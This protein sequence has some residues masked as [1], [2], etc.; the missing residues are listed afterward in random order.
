MLDWKKVL[1][2]SVLSSSIIFSSF[3]PLIGNVSTAK[4]ESHD[5]THSSEE[6]LPFLSQHVSGPFDL[7]LVNE[8]KLLPSLI[9]Q[10]IVDEDASPEE[11][12][13]QMQTYLKKRSAKAEKLAA[14][15]EDQ[16]KV[17]T[18]LQRKANLKKTAPVSPKAGEENKVKAQ[19][20]K[21]SGIEEEDWD[22]DVQTDQVL[23]LLID[24]PDYSNSSI[25][26]ADNPVLLYDNYTKEHYENMV[27]GDETYKGG[28][29]EDFISM[30]EFYEQQS[31]GSYTIDGAVSEW[32]TAE[33]PAAYYG[34]NY[35]TAEDSDIRP[36]ELIK[37]ALAHAA[38]D[39]NIDLAQFDQED[40]YDLDGDGNYREPDGIIDHLMIVHAGT[41]E[42]AGG[43]AL[44]AD[45]IWSHSWNLEDVSVIPETDGQAEVDYWGGGLAALDYT[46]QPE[47]GA[48]GV[49]AHEFGHDLGLP[50]HYDTNYT[51]G[52]VGAPT[53]YWTIMASGSW[54]GLIGGTEPTGFSPY[55]KEYLQN[56]M[57]ES[58]WFKDVEYSLE[59]IQSGKK[60]LDLDQASVKGTN[61]DSVK[62]TLPDK[63]T[64]INTPT[65]GEF[66]YHSG[67]GNDLDNN[68]ST[69]V[70]LTDVSNAE[71]TFNAFYDIEEH[72]DYAS[73]Q[74]KDGS[75]QWATV[76][77][78]I[79]T[80][81][82]PYDQSPGHGITGTSN[83]WKEASFDLS[84]FAGQ[85][86]EL[87]INYWTDGYVAMPGL[88]VDDIKVIADGADLVTDDAESETSAF[89][90]KGFTKTDGIKT[91][92]HYYL[93][94]WRNYAAAD[95]ALAHIPRGNSIMTLDP[96]MVV[97]YVDNKYDNNW[98][99]DHPG[100]GFNGV[101]DAH[102]ATAA[103]S[104]GVVGA[105][106]YQ[107][108]DAAFSLNATDKMYLD[109]KDING[110]FMELASQ[111]AKPVF[112][113]DEDYSNPGQI[114]SGRNVPGY[115]LDI[116][117]LEQ[118]AD[119]TT[120][121]VQIEFD[122]R[123]P[124]GTLTGLEEVYSSNEGHNKINVTVTANDGNLDQ[125]VTISSKVLNS[126]E[127]VVASVEDAFVSTRE[128]QDIPVEVTL[129]E[130]LESGSYTL[131][132][133]V[134][135]GTL[136]SSITETFTVD[137]EAPTPEL[138]NNGSTEVTA[139]PSVTVNV[140]DAAE[141]TLEYKWS[142]SEDAASDSSKLEGLQRSASETEKWLPFTNGDALTLSGVE[143]K[144][145]LHV[146]G[147]DI[148]G[149]NIK[150]TSNP[151]TVDGVGPAITL[152]GENPFVMDVDTEF[153]DP[154]Y[155]AEDFTDGDVTNK[156]DVSGEV[157]T[158][159]PGEYILTY[160][161]TD[162]LGNESSVQRR[163]HVVDQVNP[164]IEL[165]GESTIELE[166]GS[167]YKEPGFT[168]TDNVDGDLTDK[169]VVTGTVNTAVPGEYTLTYTVAD[170]SDNEYSVTRTVTVV[171][172]TAPA[173]ELTDGAELVVEGATTFT[174]PGFTAT[175]AVDGDLTDEVTVSG[176]VDVNTA[177][178]YILTYTVT[179]AA[180]NTAAVKRTVTVVDTTAPVI[181]LSG[182]NPVELDFGQY[183]VEP[184]F[185]AED[186]MDGNLTDHVTV[187]ST[188]RLKSGT[189]H[190]TYSVS[191]KAGNKTSVTRTVNVKQASEATLDV[192][193]GTDRVG[194]AIEVSKEMYP[195]GGAETVLITT[196]YNFP[197]ALSAG[198][199]ASALDAPIIPVTADGEL[200]SAALAEL[201]RLGAENVYLVGGKAAV[202]EGVYTQLSGIG[203]DKDNIDRLSGKDR[204]ETNLAIVTELK[205]LGFEGNGVFLATGANYAD[206][207][208]A[209]S[210][211]GA[212]GMPIV[213]TN[214]T[215]L[216]KEAEAILKGEDVYA[217]GGTAA[218]TDSVIKEAKA[219]SKSVKRLSGSDRYAT[220]VE[221]LKE[222][223]VT[224]DKIFVA[225]GKNYPDALSATPFVNQN[226]GLLLLVNPDSLPEEVKNFLTK[227]ANTTYVSAVTVLGGNSAVGTDVKEEL[228]KAVR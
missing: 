44:G 118:A 142:N 180:E 210:I 176:K 107:I 133:D 165:T 35:P 185:A 168:A 126:D 152:K 103:W 138:D 130:G 158:E 14:D 219:V 154:G 146:R 170:S 191:D 117:V 84:E 172:T 208:S 76:A 25:T 148:V 111:P 37:E 74:V 151:F 6:N 171:D 27:F 137:N 73:V 222:F 71:L 106:R 81:A 220:L 120:A 182:N 186:T 187:T 226:D 163:V 42:E 227:Y 128:S 11:Q 167:E 207:L 156:V 119:M 211:A 98:V 48:A 136:D 77:G 59:D 181:T 225:S 85:E 67:S 88:Y 68:L 56:R 30:K 80:D 21:V 72:W 92:E 115:G 203:I 129:P 33:H 228:L 60:V 89:T 55:D 63:K 113:D 139:Q 201:K 7:G 179:D 149:N 174:D 105:T 143:G 124:T 112:N 87:K 51:A 141:G 46:V 5:H 209:G 197:D 224:T 223:N 45:A 38:K 95:T 122:D 79:T 195:E 22:G 100:D 65:S 91:S 31:G 54:A 109:Y 155:T 215:D 40:L 221:L 140:K 153:V 94:E 26:E 169:V 175:D 13:K 177:G 75:G 184:G 23:V 64:V 57:P 162:S 108:Q 61:A 1:G 62:I 135:D 199:L 102:Q 189:Y 178:E 3:A 93:V 16:K 34:G 32:Y 17:R 213:L 101:V 188:L 9:K 192:V 205:E 150:F 131:L 70:D 39:P 8:E 161:A 52:G 125:E 147:K 121:K 53:D 196:G 206:A 86:I 28:N 193:S 190:V 134:S 159:V 99:G 96:G 217:A 20:N 43:G 58:N 127:E 160:S 132:V 157:N 29:G 104:D 2:T 216:S 173:I 144:W 82:N 202:N 218:I 183:F 78:N 47:D 194:T 41:G 116:S 12:R 123:T 18:E 214:G 69:K 49:F 83:G 145:Y 4:A 200:S 66:E 24:F 114:Y 166:A 15:Q 164:Y 10:G 97:W 50:D 204:Y 90:A 110:T 36:R 212:E 198:P 19:S